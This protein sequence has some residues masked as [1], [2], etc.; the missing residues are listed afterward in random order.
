MQ[1][2][3]LAELKMQHHSLNV[4]YKCNTFLSCLTNAASQS[5]C[6]IDVASVLLYKKCSTVLPLT[7]FHLITR[8]LSFS[9]SNIHLQGFLLQCGRFI[10]PPV[11]HHKEYGEDLDAHREEEDYK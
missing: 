8:P 1:H 4:L 7:T 10:E 5:Y 6:V 9:S 2:H 3:G 11:D